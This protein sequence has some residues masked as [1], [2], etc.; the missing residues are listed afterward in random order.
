MIARSRVA[1][2]LASAS[3]AA[4][5]ASLGRDL[6]K[7]AKKEPGFAGSRYRKRGR[8]VFAV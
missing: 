2:V 5:G 7:F 8:C 4:V 1:T 3:V 6:Y